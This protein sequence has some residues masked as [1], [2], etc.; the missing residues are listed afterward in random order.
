MPLSGC[1]DKQEAAKTGG[2]SGAQNQ[3]QEE[4]LIFQPFQHNF[5]VTAILFRQRWYQITHGQLHLFQKKNFRYIIWTAPRTPQKTKTFTI[6]SIFITHSPVFCWL[7]VQ[8]TKFSLSRRIKYIRM[9]IKRC[10]YFFLQS[11]SSTVYLRESARLLHARSNIY[12][13]PT[14]RHFVMALV[15]PV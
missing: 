4:L 2:Y 9:D 7:L 15:I 10:Y 8:M 3:T 1:P 14:R 13:W 5:D 6:V 12:F 11:L